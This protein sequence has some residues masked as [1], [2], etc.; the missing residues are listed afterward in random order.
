MHNLT[1]S[2]DMGRKKNTGA[3]EPSGKL[4]RSARDHGTPEGEARREAMGR[5]PKGGVPNIPAYAMT[6][7]DALL[8]HG[9]IS[10]DEHEAGLKYAALYRAVAGNPFPK[11]PDGGQPGHERPEE[12][13]ARNKE[14]L[15]VAAAVLLS[16]SRE[17]KNAVDN[18][19]VFDRWP[20]LTIGGAGIV[21]KRDNAAPLF[22]GLKALAEWFVAGKK[23]RAG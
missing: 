11:V 17:A 12:V 5:M 6:K 19:V 4:S 2:D 1:E 9:I 23:R 8:T 20:T 18:L 3:R 15:E 13:D 22:S 10:D 7:F 16:V 14:R 21:F